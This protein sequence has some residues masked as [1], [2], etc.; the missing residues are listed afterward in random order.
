MGKTRSLWEEVFREDTKSFVDYYYTH[1]A[2]RN[3][4][5]VMKDEDD[6]VSMVHLTPYDMCI[7]RDHDN[8]DKNFWEELSAFYIVGVATKEL[9]R[10]KGY[11]TLLLENAFSYM[12]E[13][14]VSLAFLMPANPAIYEP[15]GFQYIYARTDYQFC[16]E[17][18]TETEN[19]ELRRATH[20]DCQML[21][22]YAMEQLSETYRFFLKRDPSYYDILLKELASENGGLYLIYVKGKFAG[23]F[24][25]ACETEEFVQEVVIKEEYELD[26]SSHRATHVADSNILQMDLILAMTLRHKFFLISMYPELKDKIYTLREYVGE[27]ENNANIEDPYGYGKSVYSDCAKQINDCIDK[28]LVKLEKEGKI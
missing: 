20:K 21:A 12:R 2:W 22:S 16:P 25:H 6:I 3:I 7:V 4:C 14:G 9:H 24:T 17:L 10:H 26:L 8:R 1:K 19:L 23:Y 13:N 15:F 5:L 27:N 28:L 18:I 11:M